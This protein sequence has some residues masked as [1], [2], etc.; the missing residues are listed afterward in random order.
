[1]QW[2]RV[3][4]PLQRLPLAVHWLQSGFGSLASA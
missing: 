4:C 3:F 1:M 2:L